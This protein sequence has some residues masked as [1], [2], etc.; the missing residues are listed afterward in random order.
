MGDFYRK[1]INPAHT[2]DELT[3]FFP[4]GARFAVSRETI[5]RRPKADYE[6]LLA[7]LSN[8]V[9]SYAGYFMEWLWSELLVGHEQRC[10]AP[11]KVAPVSHAE[12]MDRLVQHFPKSMKR[13]LS[14]IVDTPNGSISGVISGGVPP[15]STTGTPNSL[16]GATQHTIAL[17]S[18]AYF[19]IVSH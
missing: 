6:K 10:S 12:A 2:G 8:D 16:S 9:D 18:L 15:I 4:Q 11:A 19:L 13:Q 17:A 1:Y 5:Q 14:A 7:T 3:V